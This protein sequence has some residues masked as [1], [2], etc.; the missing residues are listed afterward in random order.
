MV[1]EPKLTEAEFHRSEKAL[2]TIMHSMKGR[3]APQSLGLK[4][5]KLVSTLQEFYQQKWKEERGI[6]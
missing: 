1:K 6:W 2:T 3:G 4:Y 5:N